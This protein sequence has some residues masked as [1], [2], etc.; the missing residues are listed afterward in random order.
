M[1]KDN[2][3]NNEVVGISAELAIAEYCNINIPEDYRK[4]GSREII[5]MIKK[6]IIEDDKIKD[7]KNVVFVGS[8]KGE[9]G[10]QSKSSIDF[11]AEIKGNIVSVS[12]KSNIDTGSKVCPPELGQPCI[13]TFNELY[14]EPRGL[15]PIESG[16]EFKKIVFE[17]IDELLQ[18]YLKRLFVTDYIFHFQ[19]IKEKYHLVIVESKI[20]KDFKFDKKHITFTKPTIEDWNESNTVKYNG[21]TIG[22]FQVHNNRGS[23]K[24]RFNFKTLLE[25]IKNYE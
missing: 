16:E 11:Y 12:V 24:F 17:Q 7:F 1:E 21:K 4:R 22:E 15:N 20:S 2:K 5:D 8:K 3:L 25:L 9:R 13:A 23:L 14:T 19:K 6:S 18:E 10:K